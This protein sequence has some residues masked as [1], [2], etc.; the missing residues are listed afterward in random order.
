M[1]QYF[2]RDANRVP[3]TGLGLILKKTITFVAGTTGAIGTTTL[4]TTTGAAA[5][6]VFGFCQTDL[7]G[8]GTLEIGVAG[9]TAA[10]ANQQLATAI[11]AHEVWHDA[12]LSVGGQVAGHE[13][14]IDQ[15]IILTIATNTV[16]A[17]VI[18]FYCLWHPLAED[19]LVEIA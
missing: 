9:S 1:E 18:D 15:D 13:H 4:F 8:S 14:I 2:L 10:L 12:V 16:T 5:V 19:S 17:G 7:T 6:N 3:I 11:D